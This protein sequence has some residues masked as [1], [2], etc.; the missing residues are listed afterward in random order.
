MNIKNILY[1]S[2]LFYANF[3][4]ASPFA[5]RLM[6]DSTKEKQTTQQKNPLFMEA[7]K[8]E[9]EFM[10]A[11][12]QCSQ[13]GDCITNKQYRQTRKAV[14]SSIVDLISYIDSFE[15]DAITETDEKNEAEKIKNQLIQL[16]ENG[17]KR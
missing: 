10:H 2:F 17:T 12:A 16:L 4:H 11:Y 7:E 15:D 8:C 9:I 13:T 5:T 14:I 1:V 3:I 6:F